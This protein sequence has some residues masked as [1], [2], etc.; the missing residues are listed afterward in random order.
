MQYAKIRFTS[1]NNGS[2]AGIVLEIGKLAYM[3]TSDISRLFPMPEASKMERLERS[4]FYD[5]FEQAF[6]H[7]FN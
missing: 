5:T 6:S 4:E 3:T 1:K 7:Q 2:T